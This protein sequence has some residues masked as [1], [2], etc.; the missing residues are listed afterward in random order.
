MAAVSAALAATPPSPKPRRRFQFSFRSSF[1]DTSD[2]GAQPP[3]VRDP[4]RKY[5]SYSCYWL[6]YMLNSMFVQ[7]ISNNYCVYFLFYK[8]YLQLVVCY[9]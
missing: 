4:L 8:L 7:C 5:D 9:M 1:L 3:V 2:A 6:I